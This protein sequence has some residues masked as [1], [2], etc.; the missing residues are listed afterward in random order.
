M[1]HITWNDV[2]PKVVR[3]TSSLGWP[4]IQDRAATFEGRAR[5]RITRRGRRIT[6]SFQEPRKPDDT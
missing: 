5:E 1:K 6:M 3:A 2:I 4:A